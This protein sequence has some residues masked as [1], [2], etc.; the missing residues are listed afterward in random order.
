[1]NTLSHSGASST[2]ESV[3][4]LDGYTFQHPDYYS[5]SSLYLGSNQTDFGFDPSTSTG[6]AY[7]TYEPIYSPKIHGNMTL[8]STW[9]GFETETEG[10]RHH[11]MI[12]LGAQPSVLPMSRPFDKMQTKNPP[13]T[14]TAYSRFGQVTPPRSNSASSVDMIKEEPDVSAKS[15][16]RKKKSKVQ[17]NEPTPPST[18]TK[19][20]RKRKNSRKSFAAESKDA[21]EDDKRKM[22]LEKNRVAAAKCRVNKKEKTE[23]MQQD[24]HEK[25]VQNAFLK[26]TIMRMK[27]E[28]QHMNT[29]LL[30]HSNC[31]GCSRPE[32]VHKHLRRM[33]NDYFSHPG[34]NNRFGM[35]YTALPEPVRHMNQEQSLQDDYFS[36]VIPNHDQ[37]ML[38]NPPL[39]EYNQSDDFDL[40]T[41]QP[42]D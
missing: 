5:N 4:D 10:K 27:E 34:G 14:S 13:S 41:P 12:E 29:L 21:A 11:T 23:Q 42:G 38:D 6:S 17:F 15:S 18:S 39:P 33:G 1:M 24:S 19:P 40:Q 30:A 7:P 20:S 22:S 26:E 28:I 9:P 3:A 36:R 2:A 32:E 37:G 25:A 35:T 16:L 31:E 8:P